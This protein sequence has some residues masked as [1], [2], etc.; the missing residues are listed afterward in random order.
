MAILYAEDWAKFPTA[1]ADT[2]TKNDTFLRMAAVYREMGIYNHAFPLALVN[3]KLVGVDPFSLELTPEQMVWIALEC[4]INPWYYFREVVRIPPISGNDSIPL[5]ANRANIALFWCFFN[6]A[7]TIL[8]QP[9]QTGKSISTDTLMLLLIEIMCSNTQIN[10][11]TK[12]ETLRAANIQR[13]KNLELELPFYL[14]QRTSKD[15]NNSETITVNSLGNKYMAHVPQ[16]SPKMAYNVGRGLTSPIFQIDEGPFQ[17]NIAI[18][19]PAALAAGTA[20][21]ERASIKHEPY[22]T[23]FTTTAGKKDDRDGKYCYGLVSE[24]AEWTE[25]FLDCKNQKEFE[26]MV[27][28][29]SRTS[30][31]NRRG[32]FSVNITMNHRQ[33]GKS[34]EWLAKAIEDAK[35]HG[36][37]ADRDFGNIWTSGTA[38]HPLPLPTLELI[39]KSQASVQHTTISKIGGY[40]TRWYITESQRESYMRNNKFVMSM[41][42]SDASGG[43]DISLLLTDV[44]TGETIATGTYNET[45]LI[46][47]AEWICMDWIVKYDNI[48]VC[49]ERKSSGVAILDFL[50]LLLPAKGIDPFKRLFNRIVNE[51]EDHQ[52][53]Y[54]EVLIP[55]GRRSRDSYVRLKKY[56]GFATSGSGLTSR[57]ELYSTTLQNAARRV[58]TKVRDLTTI[59]QIAGLTTRNGRVDHEVGEHDDMVIAWL[60]NFW[61]LSQG[62][63]LS[64]YGI[65]STEILSELTERKVLNALQEYEQYEQSVL[66]Q[67]IEK[68]YND[69]KDADDPFL[70]QR[71]ESELNT[72][73]HEVILQEGEKFSVEELIRSVREEKR[74]KRTAAAAFSSGTGNYSNYSNSYGYGG[75]VGMVGGKVVSDPM[76]VF[77]GR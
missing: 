1:I 62:K 67:Q 24:A 27:R 73:D 47:L 37:D 63:N 3:R 33:L 46:T 16:K 64:H 30:P 28:K 38:S 58:G 26:L 68:L 45:N 14:R 60:L 9:R 31:D 2:S 36:E 22:G 56:F 19:L 74:K 49:I 18:S 43:D 70:V 72:L 4:K 5:M 75:G 39:R 25:R 57:N 53:A 65:L 55:V 40:V 77:Y 42:T 6:H 71:I 32:V 12:D 13:L 23:I 7:F 50:L 69:L 51:K 44:K 17:S 59:N 76:S 41:D 54:Q 48:L 8:I 61:I 29:N 15:T 52:E 66:R 34:D 11:L 20:A 10:L 21:R 35:V